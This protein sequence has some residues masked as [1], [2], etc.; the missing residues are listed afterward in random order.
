MARYLNRLPSKR[1]GIAQQGFAAQKLRSTTLQAPI[2]GWVTADSLIG[3]RPNSAQILENWFP[4]QMSMRV[5]GGARVWSRYLTGSDGIESMLVYNVQNGQ[6]L[7]VATDTEIYD[8]SASNDVY[9]LDENN[10]L[11]LDE[12]EEPIT[13]DDIPSAAVSGLTRGYWSYINFAT[14]G[15]YF[16]VAVNGADDLQLFDGA[17]W[18]AI[19]DAS[20][21]ISIQAAES[22]PVEVQTNQLSHVMAYRNR[23]F[24]VEKDT[25]RVWYLPVASI[26]GDLNLINLAGIFKRG[27]AVLMTATWSMDAGDGLDDKFVVIST[28]GEFAVF[29]GSNPN[30]DNDWEMVG[31][32]DMTAPLGP[33]AVMRAGGNLMVAT[34]EGLV[35]VAHGV[36]QDIAALSLSAVSSPIEPD[37]LEAAIERRSKP[38][39]ILKWARQGMMIVS[40]PTTSDDVT[41]HFCLACNIKTGAWAKFTGW[42]VRCMEIFNDWAFIGTRD[43]R[44]MQID[45]G[46]DDDGVSYFPTFVAS[47]DS[48][49]SPGILKDFK[50]ARATFRAATDLI[51]RIS[52]STDYEVKLPPPPNAPVVSGVPSLWDVG[53]WDQ[54]IFDEGTQKTRRVFGWSSLGAQGYSGAP[55]VQM[56]CSGSVQP[57]VE[58]IQMELTYEDGGLVV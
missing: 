42:D 21:P 38:W 31:V 26:G 35:S 23:L 22:A 51:P 3:A 49:G 9:L 4:M 33:R 27:G 52:I 56:S 17:D 24:F 57:I 45:I 55:Q 8:S 47:W 41:E 25:M 32:Y 34:I 12:D 7:F 39:E 53:R 1:S 54:A 5:R 6:K 29:Q 44:V 50:Q 46:G 40:L 30:D 11:L 13:L 58:F 15:G 36:N 18:S 20:T 10:D 19:D 43:G 48:F 2:A 14:E 37:W 16:L 28:E